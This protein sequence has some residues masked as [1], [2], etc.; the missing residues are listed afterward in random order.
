MGKKVGA[1]LSVCLFLFQCGYRLRG[2][3][4]FLPP[5]IKRVSVPMF[6]NL[7]TRFELDV[8][9]TRS[10]IDELVARGKVEV[11][12]GSETA[13]AVLV[14]EITSFTVNPIAFSDQNTADR[15]NITI[16][17]KIVLRDLANQREVF[18]NPSFVYQEEYEVPQGTDFET[19]ENQAISKV[20]EKFARSLV[21][22]ILEGF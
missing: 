7:T 21:I 22:T 15:Y 13:D 6:K 5:H 1:L 4:S 3:G 18:S 16:V 19:W 10:V 8:R 14:G 12:A 11:A 20:A 9:L 2:T 17:A